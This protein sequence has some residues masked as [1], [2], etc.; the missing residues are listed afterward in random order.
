MLLSHQKHIKAPAPPAS[1][2]SQET[3]DLPLGL[4]QPPVAPGIE[5]AEPPQ[6][7]WE[8]QGRVGFTT[9][10]ELGIKTQTPWNLQ[11]VGW[12]YMCGA[13]QTRC[14]HAFL[15]TLPYPHWS[16]PSPTGSFSFLYLEPFSTKVMRGEGHTCAALIYKW[17][18][19]ARDLP[20]PPSK[21]CHVALFSWAG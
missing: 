1:R 18:Q 7:S 4:F 21:G 8:V 17:L 19:S 12:S 16:I 5:G 15:P 6:P 2:V 11:K 13:I 14:S 10:P 9:A 20:A 3:L